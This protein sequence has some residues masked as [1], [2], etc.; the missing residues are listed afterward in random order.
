[1]INSICSKIVFLQLFFNKPKSVY[2]NQYGVDFFFQFSV[3]NRNLED[4]FKCY[5]RIQFRM[6][7]S[8]THCLSYLFNECP[9]YAYVPMYFYCTVFLNL[10]LLL[11]IIVF[12]K[13]N[14]FILSFLFFQRLF[15][16]RTSNIGLSS[17]N[18]VLKMWSSLFMISNPS[19]TQK[20][21][22]S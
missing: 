12:K 21:L 4:S 6:I 8:K 2:I 19:V 3:F 22:F 14:C 20:E 18:L 15:K 10:I 9:R 16:F 5:T 11:N 17:M 7:W 13:A 1:M